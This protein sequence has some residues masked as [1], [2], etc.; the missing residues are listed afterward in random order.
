MSQYGPE[1]DAWAKRILNEVVPKVEG[2]DIFV[3][4]TPSSPD[5]VDV[6]FAVELGLAIMMDKPIIATMQ[7]G[8]KIP[9]KLAA[10]VDEFVEMDYDNIP[11][12]SRRLGEVAQ[13][14]AEKLKKDE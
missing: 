2:S 12:S 7:P 10:V 8:T 3:S 4:V 14:L 1:F 5:K 9:A 13:E 11:D 6:K